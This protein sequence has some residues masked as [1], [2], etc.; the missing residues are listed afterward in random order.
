MTHNR[1]SEKRFYFITFS[2]VAVTAK[3]NFKTDGNE[4]SVQALVLP[5]FSINI[6]WFHQMI[7]Q[8]IPRV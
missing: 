6:L 2:V 5:H 1:I 7:A 3:R 4:M 8:L